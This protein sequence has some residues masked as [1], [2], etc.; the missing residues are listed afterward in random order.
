MDDD[1]NI[2]EFMGNRPFLTVFILLVFAFIIDSAMTNA[3]VLRHGWPE[4][5]CECEQENEQDK[6]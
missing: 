1:M 3:N 4:T 5:Y 6:Q 2:L